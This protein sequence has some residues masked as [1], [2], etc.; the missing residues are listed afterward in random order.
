MY[1]IFSIEL[2]CKQALIWGPSC[3][4]AKMFGKIPGLPVCLHL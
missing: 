4:G 3:V 2:N 1:S